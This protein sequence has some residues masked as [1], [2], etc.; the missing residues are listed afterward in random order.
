MQFEYDDDS[1]ADESKTYQVKF[2]GTSSK[3]ELEGY[4]CESD[5]ISVL[6]CMDLIRNATGE[7]M[8]V[9][10]WSCF[11]EYFVLIDAPTGKYLDLE[12]LKSDGECNF[13]RM[14]ES[15]I[16][17]EPVKL[18]LVTRGDKIV[19]FLSSLKQMRMID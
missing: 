5:G 18:K 16:I 2:R 7:K 17:S 11:D 4:D 12:D 6:Y 9:F 10:K 19:E 14:Y 8:P 13:D 1:D 3:Y 15:T